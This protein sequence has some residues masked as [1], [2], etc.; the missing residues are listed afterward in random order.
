MDYKFDERE[1]D[2]TRMSR[3]NIELYSMLKLI[4][5]SRTNEVDFYKYVAYTRKLQEGVF[6]L[7]EELKRKLRDC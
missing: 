5:H 2:I 4:E 7:E 3:A 6:Q 1:L